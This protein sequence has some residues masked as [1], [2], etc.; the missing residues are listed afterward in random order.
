M[1]YVYVR[2][3]GAHGVFANPV[4]VYVKGSFE[5]LL[6]SDREIW[7]GG[8]GSGMIREARGPLTFFTDEGRARWEAAGSPALVHGPRDELFSEGCLG[9]TPPWLAKLLANREALGAELRAR[10]MLSLH[11][12][13]QLLGETLVT[14]ALCRALYEIAKR[15]PNMEVLASATDQ[16]GRAGHGVARAEDGQRIELIF[17]PETTELL[18]CHRFLIDPDQTYAPVGTLVSWSSYLD[19]QLVDSPPLGTP[20]TPDPPCDPPGAGGCESQG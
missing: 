7:I 19:R 13:S 15:L 4:P 11:D 20:P 9:S 6:G 5:V 18:A 12:I 10:R 3:C 16:L 17:D 1:D 8:D 2:S 14:P